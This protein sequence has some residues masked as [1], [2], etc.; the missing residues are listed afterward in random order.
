[1]TP[2]IENA[3]A[4]PALGTIASSNGDILTGEPDEAKFLGDTGRLYPEISLVPKAPPQAM[5]TIFEPEADVFGEDLGDLP[6]QPHGAA[7]TKRFYIW[8]W[9]AYRDIFKEMHVTEFCAYLNSIQV[10]EDAAHI[11]PIFDNCTRHNC[12]DDYCADHQEIEAI[13]KKARK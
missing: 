11:N 3:G 12:T 9:I 1:V 8:G 13:F 7:Y 4:T 2:T 5:Q 10:G 6:K